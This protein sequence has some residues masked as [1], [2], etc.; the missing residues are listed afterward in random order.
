MRE[1][2][3]VLE[4]RNQREINLFM[5]WK[6]KVS[7]RYTWVWVWDTI[8]LIFLSESVPTKPEIWFCI[9]YSIYKI[10]Y[11]L[12]T[13]D[14]ILENVCIQMR[15]MWVISLFPIQLDVYCVHL[16]KYCWFRNFV[17]LPSVGICIFIF[18]CNFE[19][20]HPKWGLYFH[21]NI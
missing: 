17:Y 7:D 20:P 16:F 13:I 9:S 21:R 10:F 5:S 11:I 2:W 8:T 1:C 12:R 19:T 18:H 14:P 6:W 3:L 4:V 15:T